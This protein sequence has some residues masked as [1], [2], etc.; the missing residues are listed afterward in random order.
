M[1]DVY[2]RQVI[3]ENDINQKV[4]GGAVQFNWNLDHH[5]FMIGMSLDSASAD[6]SNG[7]RLGFFDA[8]RKGYLDQNQ[9]LDVFA[10]ADQEIRNNDFDGT[11]I[12]QSIY[13]S[14][15]WSPIKTLHVTG[16]LRYNATKVKN[17]LAVREAGSAVD[18]LHKYVATPD[19]YNL[20]TDQDGN[21]IIEPSDCVGVATGYKIPDVSRLLN[22]AETESFSYYSLN[23]SLGATWQAT[24]NLNIYGNVAQGTRCL[25]YTSRCV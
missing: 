22:P 9:A 11:S 2:K 16:A 25:L 6:Y 24:P 15:T 21:G 3:T 18:A 12:T 13:A 7:Q 17:T 20:C 23:P 4:K 5:K 14:E 19:E 1:L 10:A 8:K